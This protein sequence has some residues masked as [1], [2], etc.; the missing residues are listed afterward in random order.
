MRGPGSNGGAGIVNASGPSGLWA[1][2]VQARTSPASKNTV[3]GVT[4]DTALR[5]QPIKIIEL[6]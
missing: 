6:D 5:Q 1:P 3:L 2:Y 4:I